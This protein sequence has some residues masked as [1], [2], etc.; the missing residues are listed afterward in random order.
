MKD[1][2]R[3]FTSRTEGN[4]DKINQIVWKDTDSMSE[5]STDSISELQSKLWHDKE[6]LG[7]ILRRVLKWKSL[8]QDGTKCF[9]TGS[10]R[11]P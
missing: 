10:K 11:M 4:L 9:H 8:C 1:D 7:T 5:W 6:T 2:E 3:P